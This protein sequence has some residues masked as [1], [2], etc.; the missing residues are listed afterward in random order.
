MLER[1]IHRTKIHAIHERDIESII[2]DLGLYD[3]IAV[4][5]VNCSICGKKIRMDNILSIYME[6]EEIMLC[7]DSGE[8]CEVILRKRD[9]IGNE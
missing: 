8:C 4:G 7:C 6:E 3:K 5:E 2:R 9:R 1:W